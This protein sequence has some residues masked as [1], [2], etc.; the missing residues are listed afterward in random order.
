MLVVVCDH[1][2]EGIAVGDSPGDPGLCDACRA[3]LA[4]QPCQITGC[5]ATHTTW[6]T[7][8]V[9][10]GTYLLYPVCGPHERVIRDAGNAMFPPQAA[11]PD[12]DLPDWWYE[13]DLEEWW[14][15]YLLTYSTPPDSP[16]AATL[17]ARFGPGARHVAYESSAYRGGV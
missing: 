17:A 12:G 2:P 16:L 15:A 14:D 9:A 11:A 10:E 1:A 6:I 13:A 3:Q 8:V 7:T 4:R 5:E